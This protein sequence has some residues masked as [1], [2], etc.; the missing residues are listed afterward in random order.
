MEAFLL[1]LLCQ[2][3]LAEISPV[4][5]HTTMMHGVVVD[6]NAGRRFRVYADLWQRHTDQHPSKCLRLRLARYDTSYE[7]PPSAAGICR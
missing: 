5:E 6:D 1:L 4:A 3:A 7:T 2:D